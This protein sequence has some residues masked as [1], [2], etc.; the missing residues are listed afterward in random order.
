[1]MAYGKAET[2]PQDRAGSIQLQRSIRELQETLI[3][4]I[5][6]LIDRL[7]NPANFGE[8]VPP[9]NLRARINDHVQASKAMRPSK[10]INI[11]D[12]LA[13]V[14]SSSERVQAR[15]DEI[16]DDIIV[17][18][19]QTVDKNHKISSQIHTIAQHTEEEVGKLSERIDEILKRQKSFQAVLDATSG[20]NSLLSFLTEYLSKSKSAI[21]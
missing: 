21:V 2:I 8:F 19:H 20:Q 7:L 18:A 4:T 3:R 15:A 17:N 9:V 11:D 6:E 16:I 10:D 5:P 14:R 13:A 12:L 1:M